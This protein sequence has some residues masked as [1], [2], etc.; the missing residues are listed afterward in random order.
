MQ[1]RSVFFLAKP[2]FLQCFVNSSSFAVVMWVLQFMSGL[3]WAIS[4]HRTFRQKTWKLL[5]DSWHPMLSPWLFFGF[6]GS[7][8]PEMLVKQVFFLR[9]FCDLDFFFSQ[10][11]FTR[12]GCSDNFLPRPLRKSSVSMTLT[13]QKNS[14]RLELSIS[15][16]T[17]H[18]RWGQGPG[19]VDSRLTPSRFAFPGARNPRIY[20]ISRFGKFFPAIFPGLS[21]SFPREPPNRPR[22]QPQPS[23]VF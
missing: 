5:H 21:R 18:G 6:F 8:S 10:S 13:D 12:K 3:L 1:K 22:K 2:R 19:S 4:Q 17:P 16:D 20:S 23:R 9:T 7:A 11:R 14:R 15:K